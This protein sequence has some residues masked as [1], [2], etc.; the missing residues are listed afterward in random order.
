MNRQYTSTKDSPKKE[1]HP[2][3]SAVGAD[4]RLA[5]H[6]DAFANDTCK[7]A[8]KETY[9]VRLTSERS[10]LGEPASEVRKACLQRDHYC[11]L[12]QLT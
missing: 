3:L 1:R 7:S 9:D 6:L 4:V 5:W 2:R 12:H 11:G 8:K 10:K